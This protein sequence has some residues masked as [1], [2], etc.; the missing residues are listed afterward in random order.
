MSANLLLP[1]VPSNRQL[2]G[3]PRVYSQQVS[4]AELELSELAAHRP[5]PL[6]QENA[7]T[8]P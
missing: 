1:V 2:C 3:Y 8:R 6:G 7:P 5:R 4:L